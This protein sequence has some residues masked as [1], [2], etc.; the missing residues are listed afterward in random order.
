[1]SVSGIQFRQVSYG[2]QEKMWVEGSVLQ[3]VRY[4]CCWMEYGTITETGKGREIKN[5]EKTHCWEKTAQLL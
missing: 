5:P 3:Q 4:E 1:M 2:A